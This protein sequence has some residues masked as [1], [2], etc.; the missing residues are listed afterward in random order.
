VDHLGGGLHS[1]VTLRESRAVWLQPI[2]DRESVN[3]IKGYDEK[4]FSLNEEALEQRE[5][6]ITMTC[7]K[8]LQLQNYRCRQ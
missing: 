4:V 5:P 7:G 3:K 2:V 6:V 8:G 1:L